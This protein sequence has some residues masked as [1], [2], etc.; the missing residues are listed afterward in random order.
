MGFLTGEGKLLG[1]NDDKVDSAHDKVGEMAQGEVPGP[2]RTDRQSDAVR[3]G[4]RL[5]RRHEAGGEAARR[6]SRRRG[7]AAR[8]VTRA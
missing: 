6:P 4:L 8:A 3:Q 1:K 2:R 5:Q 7:E